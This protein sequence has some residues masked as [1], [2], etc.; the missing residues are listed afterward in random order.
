M[1]QRG[2]ILVPAQDVIGPRTILSVQRVYHKYKVNCWVLIMRKQRLVA[3]LSTA[4]AE[5]ARVTA[6]Q[7]KRATWKI[8][9]KTH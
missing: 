7:D 8:D 1:F 6:F 5:Y 4:Q 2:P 9:Q 3:L